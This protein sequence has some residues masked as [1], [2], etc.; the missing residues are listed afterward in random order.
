MSGC[1]LLGWTSLLLQ[2]MLCV[3]A[4][5]AL[6]V[7]RAFEQPK[8]TRIVFFLD[9]M[10]QGCGWGSIHFLNIFL[11]MLFG[12]EAGRDPCVWVSGATK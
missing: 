3:L 1:A 5:G 12:G 11:S 6:L 10:K 7:K 9:L 4:L 8:R 2:L